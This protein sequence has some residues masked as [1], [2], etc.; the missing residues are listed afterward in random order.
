MWCMLILVILLFLLFLY[1]VY[2]IYILMS[3]SYVGEVICLFGGG[4]CFYR[5]DVIL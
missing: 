4:E 5:F 1:G 2:Y 3:G